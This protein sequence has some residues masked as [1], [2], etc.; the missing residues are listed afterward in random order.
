MV[1]SIIGAWSPARNAVGSDA[2]QFCDQAVN[3][4]DRPVS[5][6]YHPVRLRT[7]ETVVEEFRKTSICDAAMRVVA[8]KGLKNVTVQDIADEAGV[9][10][11]TVYLYFDSRE[12]ILAKTMD[13]AI[14]NLLER[15]SN[16]CSDCRGFREILEQRVRTQLQHFEEN[17]DFFR[18]YLATAEPFGEKRLKKHPAYLTYLAQLERILGEAIARGEIRQ[19]NVERLAIAMSSVVRDIVLHRVIE[20]DPP[21]LEE[22]VTFAVDFIMRG[23]DGEAAAVR[24]KR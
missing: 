3:R 11:G 17:R 23:I 24:R 19:A 12:E 21:P 8:R 13:E 2:V 18:V 14:E 1:R 20:R 22:D 16:A 5:P 15:L 4:I 6:L 10:K 7:K 9:A